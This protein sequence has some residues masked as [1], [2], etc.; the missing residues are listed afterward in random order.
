VELGAC[1]GVVKSMKTF[2]S[3]RAL[4]LDG[5]MFIGVLAAKDPDS[6]IRLGKAGRSAFHMTPSVPSWC[7][8]TVRG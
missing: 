7:R 2:A 8:L 3:D 5:C 4:Q 1:E 6:T